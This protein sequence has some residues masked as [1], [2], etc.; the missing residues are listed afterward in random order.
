MAACVTAPAAAAAGHG[1]VQLLGDILGAAGKTGS[2]VHQGEGHTAALDQKR[3]PK[4]PLQ[5][6]VL[7]KK[8]RGK[9]AGR[10]CGVVELNNV[11]DRRWGR[12]RVRVPYGMHTL[13]IHF[14]A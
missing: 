13:F 8:R 3:P 11:S 2:L 5:I 9:R 12:N 7:K 6:G 10:V 4:P 14:T 1:I